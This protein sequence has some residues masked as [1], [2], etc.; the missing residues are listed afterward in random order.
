MS[1]KEFVRDWK[2]K[3]MSKD[4][5][6][7]MLYDNIPAMV[8]FYIK[9]GHAD[10]DTVNKL[11]DKM[12]DPK[13]PKTLLRILKTQDET[14]VELGM[15][16]VIADFLERRH[17][18]VDEETLGMYDES[19]TKILK[20]RMKK[21]SKKLGLEKDILKELLVVVP[22]TDVM[23][24]KKFIGIYVMKMLRRLYILAKDTDLGLED[25]KTVKKLFK[26]LF[27]DDQ[28]DNIAINVLL[29]R[30][31][32]MKNFGD[33]QLAVWNLMTSFALETLEDHKKKEI[34]EML[35]H[36]IGRRAKD[37]EKGRDFARRVQL[38]Q[39]AEDNYPKLAAAVEDLCEKDKNKKFL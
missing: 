27:G 29:E 12:E 18:K 38:S 28:I 31:E 13:F 39:V 37:A 3:K 6:T 19:V 16:V 26:A 22:D 33:R 5:R 25:V 4:D 7:Y 2:P 14:P 24:D 21:L 10:Q 9:R 23:S 11:F 32:G 36:Y 20:P 30:K 8:S 35:E 17:A 34:K 15:A 1:I